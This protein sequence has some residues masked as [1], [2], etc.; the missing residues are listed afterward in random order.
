M[1]EI[2]RFC[3]KLYAVSVLSIIVCAMLIR[4]CFQPFFIDH[5]KVKQVRI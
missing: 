5:E 2:L 4:Q 1:F 3:V